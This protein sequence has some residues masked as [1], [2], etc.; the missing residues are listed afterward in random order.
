[1]RI[2][3]EGGR[4][5]GREGEREEGRREREGRREGRSKKEEGGTYTV[6][7]THAL[8][9]AHTQTHTHRAYSSA[10]L[11]GTEAL[12]GRRQSSRQGS[13]DLCPSGHSWSCV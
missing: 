2:R 9:S 11:S 13:T 7:K 1:M 5:G 12:G 4:E 3:P 8:L 6:V 10:A